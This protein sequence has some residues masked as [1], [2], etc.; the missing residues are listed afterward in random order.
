VLYRM[1]EKLAKIVSLLL[2][3]GYKYDVFHWWSIAISDSPHIS[4]HPTNS[5]RYT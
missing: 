4:P 2:I 1:S 3:T 5:E